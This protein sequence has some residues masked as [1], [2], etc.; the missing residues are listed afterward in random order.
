MHHVILICCACLLSVN[1]SELPDW[2]APFWPADDSW[3]QV[4]QHLRFNN[5]SDP[6]TLDPQLNKT[7][8]GG[9]LAMALFE[10]LVSN[11]PTDL[12][13][14][15]GVAQRWTVSEDGLRYTFHLRPDAR[16][17]DGRAITAAD[18]VGSWRRA[19]DPAT[20]SSYAYMLFPI[21]NAEAVYQQQAAADTLGVRALDEHT[22]TVDLAGP[23]PYF[24]D[25][26]AFETLYPVPLHVIAEHGEN[27]TRPGLMVGNGPFQLHAWKPRQY[28]EM[29]KNPHYWDAA[30]VKLERITAYPY[31]D[32]EAAYNLFRQGQLD[33]ICGVP[34]QRVRELEWDPDYYAAPYL[35]SYFYRINCTR[36]P[37]D[38]RRVRQALSLTVD[39]EAVV[40][41]LGAGERPSTA[42]VP[43]LVGGYEPVAGLSANPA[44][45]REL[46]AEAGFPEGEGFPAFELWYNNSD[47]HK[48]VAETIAESWRQQLGVTA[49]LRNCEW[50]LFVKRQDDLQYDVSRAG[51]IGDYNDPNT[52]LNLFASDGGNNRTGWSNAAYDRL[53][54]AS[55]QTGDPA[56][57]RQLFA[58]MEHILVER[59]FPIIP[60]YI[61]VYTGMMRENLRGIRL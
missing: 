57:R 18:F 50:R 45:A 30:F 12:Q 59:E 56:E 42:L 52:F 49:K 28:L 37:F 17:S 16:W 40:R 35:G 43:P 34:K 60:L 36:K 5:E 29:R 1:A 14:R 20:G 46:L 31:E 3:R 4:D 51:W 48:K 25:L 38:D 11:D 39:R 26:C 8:N 55:Q 24:L 7:V 15:P 22:L 33:W 23:C 41:V 58:Q 9:R 13:I 47:D 27:W 54:A 53:L 6:A 44:R 21:M 32:M 10:G 2:K 19:L 61:Y